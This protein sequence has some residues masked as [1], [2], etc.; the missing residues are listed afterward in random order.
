MCSSG[1]VG[2]TPLPVRPQ[3]RREGCS[4]HTL[5]G[6]PWLE[7]GIPHRRGTSQAENVFFYVEGPVS[8]TTPVPGSDPLR[9]YSSPLLPISEGAHPASFAPVSSSTPY[10]PSGQQPWNERTSGEA[11]RM[12]MGP[13]Q[14][15]MHPRSAALS[16]PSRSEAPASFT[17]PYPVANLTVTSDATIQ[18]PNPQPTSGTGPLA[19]S[20]WA[21]TAV[22]ATP[23]HHQLYHGL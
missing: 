22:A 13:L 6:G 11:S 17:A 9:S 10:V 18:S 15:L 1:P 4:P 21:G 8:T 20:I 2:T 12:F 3:S 5:P 7:S 19:S 23:I 16:T 14:Q